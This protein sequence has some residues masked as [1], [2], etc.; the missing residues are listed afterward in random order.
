MGQHHSSWIDRISTLLCKKNSCL[1]E[2]YIH[3]SSHKAT[4]AYVFI[5]LIIV[6]TVLLS[7]FTKTHK[8]FCKSAWSSH[9]HSALHLC[10]GLV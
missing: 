6:F 5:V 3:H 8:P 7:I 2:T 9:N 4:I 10:M 1:K